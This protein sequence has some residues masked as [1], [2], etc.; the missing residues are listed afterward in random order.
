MTTKTISQMAACSH[1]HFFNPFCSRQTSTQKVANVFFYA[2]G[3]AAIWFSYRA[4]RAPTNSVTPQSGQLDAPLTA[5]PPLKVVS[6]LHHSKT[7][8]PINFSES[9]M[10]TLISTEQDIARLPEVVGVSLATI[11]ER[12]QSSDETVDLALIK[13][14]WDRAK[15]AKV[16]H[17]EI[18]D[19]LHN[20]I[21]AA[22]KQTP[23][24]PVLYDWTVK[25]QTS[26]S[27]TVSRFSVTFL[28]KAEVDIFCSESVKRT[29]ELTEEEAIII[30]SAVPCEVIK[31]TSL[32]ESYIRQYGFYS[33]R[34][35]LETVLKI[36][37][38]R[39]GVF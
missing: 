34:L 21:E 5:S 23:G 4:F 6:T 22:K 25:D 33:A 24:K 10:A 1:Y 19:H 2:L 16:T 31:W 30:N 26:V 11:Q 14:D 28:K 27:E 9:K 13:K 20:I 29:C 12:A 18:A 38:A 15:A 17:I 36:L 7:P 39:P 3:A 32:R 8:P 37:K 35:K